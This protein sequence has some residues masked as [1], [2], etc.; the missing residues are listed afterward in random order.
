MLSIF[1]AARRDQSSL[2]SPEA[3]KWK[4]LETGIATLLF[5]F[6][7]L[8]ALTQFVNPFPHDGWF[9][10]QYQVF[11]RSPGADNYT[12]VAVP[13]LLYAVVHFVTAL[14]D[15]GLAAEFYLGSLL[16]HL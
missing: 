9:A 5:L 8:V 10:S 14:F 7:L 2:S 13:A 3:Q 6:C 1:T 11:R 12:P 4:W 16:H 15:R